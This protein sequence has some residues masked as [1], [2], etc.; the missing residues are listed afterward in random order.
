MNI[1]YSILISLTVSF[2]F[3]FT[4][5]CDEITSGEL[6]EL[7]IDEVA[8]L[9][10][11]EVGDAKANEL[12]SCSTM[13]IGAKPCGGPWGYIV[14][15]TEQSDTNKL[16]RLVDRYNELDDIRNREKGLGSMCDFATKPELELIGGQC[17]GDG[18]YAWNA[19]E[20]S[21]RTQ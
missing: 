17:H 8:K 12:S 1:P 10:E 20:I 19:G 15:S 21:N 3:L 14:Y 2:I 16:Q 11:M 5:A 9:I 6:N 13:A 4:T 18:H 7:S